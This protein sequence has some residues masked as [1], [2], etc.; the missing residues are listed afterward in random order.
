MAVRKFSF[1]NT[2][3]G[4]QEEFAD[5]DSALL[6]K[7]TLSGISGVAIDAGGQLVSNLATPVSA[8]DATTKSYV[9]AI[10]TGL[11]VK[12]S[13][14][15]KST[16]DFSTYT[17]AGSGAG[18]T[19]T[20]AD[21]NVAH[22]T[23]DGVLLVVGNRILV[24]TAGGDDS[25]P[26]SSNGIYV[27]TTLADGAGQELV[28][29]RSADADNS[30]SGE[31]TAGMFTFV[32]EG[33]ANGDTGWVLV[34][35]DPITLDTTALAF[36]QFS[37]TVA[38]T[39][40]QGL[41]NTGGSIKVEVDTGANAQGAGAGGGSSGL[42]FDAN[43]AAGKLR[44]AV[45][46]TGGLERTATGLAVKIDDS[47][48]TLDSG[49]GG[50]KVTGVP[51][52]FKINGTATGATVTAANLGT[53]TDGSNA[54]ALHVHAAV[55][56]TEAP[57]VENTLT[58]DEAIAAGDPV[59]FSTSTNDR[60]VKG[61][62]NSDAKSRIIGVARTAAASAGNPTEVVTAGPAT[63]TLSGATVGTPYYLQAAGGV[64]TSLPGAGNR[65]VQVGIAKNATDL[66]VRV[67]DY[68]KK[69]A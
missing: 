49:A 42:E 24:T 41:S 10:A 3:E 5:T 50:L 18:A 28:L 68:G 34:T 69:A 54:D 39:F 58:A 45:H 31:V 17:Q 1:I 6:G 4:F 46:A 26:D 52:L 32:A 35:N 9:D 60:V 12:G 13:V 8:G 7:L 44:A 37:S 14:R 11:D 38:Y 23:Q 48:D 55:A 29:T 47:P 27:V 21:D 64:G 67:I 20:S 63:G 19:L 66:F 15:V 59:A 25:T 36:S 43:T 30:P 40:D 62:A 57:K 2:T 56:A 22:N 65:L 53:L 61:L 16:E 33:T 51:S